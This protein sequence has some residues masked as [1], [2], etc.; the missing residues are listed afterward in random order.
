MHLWCP[1][2]VHPEPVLTE[3]QHAVQRAID[4]EKPLAISRL[5][6]LKISTR[7]GRPWMTFNCLPKC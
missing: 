2:I 4:Q 6:V 3:L 7:L 5:L 1:G